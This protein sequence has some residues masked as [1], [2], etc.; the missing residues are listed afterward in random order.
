MVIRCV[1]RPC[2]PFGHVF[3]RF[4]TFR[5]IM[6]IWDFCLEISLK[7]HWNFL[8]LVCG[9]HGHCCKFTWQINSK[10]PIASS[11]VNKPPPESQ[12][13]SQW[14]IYM[15]L[16]VINMPLLKSHR[17]LLIYT[18]QLL[19]LSIFIPLTTLLKRVI[20]QLFQCLV[21]L[22]LNQR[23]LEQDPGLGGPVGGQHRVFIKL[24]IIIF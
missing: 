7:N 11:I 19:Y 20:S 5:I 21:D 9:N 22:N 15:L 23:I 13:L 24:E 2:I 12:R 6:E 16:W 18:S 14:G 8:R 10:Q 4:V 3:F 17:S 1:R